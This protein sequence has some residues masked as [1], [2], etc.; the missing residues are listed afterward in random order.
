M[1]RASRLADR[2]AS[3]K[4]HRRGPQI[5]EGLGSSGPARFRSLAGT[6]LAYQGPPPKTVSPAFCDAAYVR[7]GELKHITWI[8]RIRLFPL[9]VLRIKYLGLAGPCTGPRTDGKAA[10]VT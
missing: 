4:I 10:R 7:I 5:R 2:S 1:L 9:S 3:R 6:R 8:R